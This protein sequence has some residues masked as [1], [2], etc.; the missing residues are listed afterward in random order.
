M[1]N[2]QAFTL[3]ELLV[4][5]L[6]IGI[7]AAVAL[8]Q[9]QMAVAKS[10][11]V[12]AK[13]LARAL[14]QAGE[15]Y[16]LSNGSYPYSFDVL[17]VDTPA[18]D[19]EAVN[20]SKNYTTRFFSWGRCTSWGPD[21]VSCHITERGKE[22]AFSAGYNGYQD[23]VGYTTDTSHLVNKLC[24]ADTGLITPSE[25]GGFYLRWIYP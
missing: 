13:T 20:E 19:S 10:H 16:Y 11:F 24:K 17:D 5:V 21:G 23:C 2:N 18:Y 4:V 25:T 1:K 6:I 12:Q 14:A 3:I 15:S 9:Y 8:P 7:L 22:L